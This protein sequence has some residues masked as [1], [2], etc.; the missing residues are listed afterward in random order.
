M[1]PLQRQEKRAGRVGFQGGWG[2]NPLPDS[3]PTTL[4]QPEQWKAASRS[5]LYL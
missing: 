3:V 5:N 1:T 4:A 2:F